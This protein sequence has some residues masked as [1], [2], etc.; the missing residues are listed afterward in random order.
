MDPQQQQQQQ[1]PVLNV[2][3]PLPD[4]VPAPVEKPTIPGKEKLD[5]LVGKAVGGTVIASDIKPQDLPHIDPVR[6]SLDAPTVATTPLLPEKQQPKAEKVNGSAPKTTT[7]TTATAEDKAAATAAASS[8]TV[9]DDIKNRIV[10]AYPQMTRIGWL[11]AYKRTDGPSNEFRDKSIWMDEFASSAMYG[12]FWHNAAAMFLIPVVCFIVFKL[13][14]GFVS[15][16]LIIAF[17]ATYYKNSIRRFRRNARDDLT[18]ELIK[19]AL[20]DNSESVEWINNFM[21]KFWLIYEPVLSATVVGVVD[22]ILVDQTPAFLDSIRLT[23]FTLGTK[24]PRVDNIKTYPHTDPDVVM[25]DWRVSFTPT[26]IEDMTPR[27]LRSQVNPKVVLTVRVGKGIVG[28]GMPILVE[29]MSFKGYFRIKLKLTSNFPHI[30]TL[31]FSF[32]E[33]P[34]IDYVL[35]PVG[36]ETF[37][38]DIAHI[39]GLQSFIRDQTHAILGPMM[40]NPNVFTLDLEQIMTGGASLTA[41]IGV[42]QFTVYN[43]KDLK[44]TELVGNS[45]P[46]MKI[47]L[48]N[49]PELAQTSVKQ[50]TLN[51]IWNETF[52]IL[53]N[54]L[55]EIVVMEI[56]DKDTMRKDRPLGQANFDLKALE[57]DPLQ[58]DVWCKI[59][60]N[61]K[62]R[63]ATRIR[64]AFF[65]IEKP[66]PAED[67]SG[68]LIPV[69][70]NAGIL[71][72]NVAQ[73]KDIARS[74]R[75]K[76]ICNVYLNGKLAH[77]T[78]KLSGTSPAWGAN[79]EMFITDLLN[80]TI[81]FEIVAD[82]EVIGK[83]RSAAVN[84]IDDT[85]NKVDWVTVQGGDGTGKLRLNTEWKPI[86]MSDD[87]NPS[88]HKPAFGVVRIKL[89]AG[90]DLRNVEATGKSDP[91]VVI[92]GDKNVR[93]GRTKI[94]DD[95]L[96]P[97]WNE[98][99]YVA[100]NS[101]KQAIE[102]EVFDYQKLT[103]DRTLGKA[104]F[105]IADL[106]DELPD[107]AGYEARPAIDRW[108]PLLQKDGGAKGELHYVISFHPSLK[109]A[110]EVTAAE[111]AAAPIETAAAAAKEGEAIANLQRAQEALAKATLEPAASAGKDIA[112]AAVDVAAAALPANTVTRED[113]LDYE[114]GILVA[115][116]M[117]AKLDKSN[118][119]CEFYVDSDEYQYK[120]QPQ[121]SRNPKWHE[122]ADIF[123]KELEY[124]KLVVM[125]KEKSSLEKDPIVGVMTG[126]IRTL[127]ETTPP[128]GAEIPILDKTDLRGKIHLKFEYLPVPIELEP[129]ER[130][131]NMGNLSCNLIRGRN[132]LAADRG[133]S[134]DPYVVFRLNGKEVYKSEC[135]K[136]T[137]DPEFGEQFVIPIGSRAEDELVLEVFDWNQ[138]SAAKSLGMARVPLTNLQLVIPNEF[139]LKLQNKSNQ[140]EIHL[141]VKFM[142]EFLS[143]NKRRSGLGSTF[144]SG[145]AHLVT[146]GANLVGN[147][148]MAGINTVGAVGHGAMDVGG[149]VGRGAIKGVGGA[150]KG[151]GA[152]GK[153]VF[154]GLS[155]GASA[156]GLRKDKEKNGSQSTIENTSSPALNASPKLQDTPPSSAVPQ[157]ETPTQSTLGASPSQGSLLSA[158]ASPLPRTSVGSIRSRSSMVFDS[159]DIVGEPGTLT[160][161]II[162]A[163]GLQ[164]VDKSGLSDP[165]VR[166]KMGAKGLFK[167]KVKK[168]NLH[169]VWN[170]DC[171]IPGLTGH[172]VA[173]NFCVKDHNKLGSDKDLGD[174]DLR[175]WEYLQPANES[176]PGEYVADFWAPLSGA[177]GRIHLALAFEP[178]S[179]RRP[180]S[181]RGLFRK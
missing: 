57:L 32:L 115:H 174:F 87:L 33:P 59:L 171:V 36:G 102:L 126:N 163:D 49:R 134:S 130:L 40:Y 105:T 104:G 118:T 99:H 51:P 46:Y 123:V 175:V 132:L 90:R 165:Y 95:N 42:V 152:V 122:V 68:T 61:G 58:D 94:I 62:E 179:G 64:A 60:R 137:L 65:P 78:S 29:D 15:L 25:M 111:R 155:A 110:K 11:E 138:I 27:Q 30:K 178:A 53:V 128:D 5:E 103:K 139:A 154:G 121:K 14:G 98:I 10:G 92:T 71:A 70:S 55:N 151:V 50:D 22:G 114:S 168:E 144:V 167:T 117:G 113:A 52:T 96:N 69:E 79:V 86:L 7:A 101:M 4:D 143:S 12:A 161:Q 120:S 19:N 35:K 176:H 89:L 56:L 54:N 13:G 34:T 148:G 66:K 17:G 173:I 108:A 149:A 9:V 44:N 180:E 159:N 97:V 45:D 37:G 109:V 124:A 93:R 160:V 150:A 76:S 107:K 129:K 31:D 145:G 82:G 181:K 112:D 147:V 85:K 1:Q 88:M 39:P 43:A 2:E 75:T 81:D 77:T 8:A 47:R 21:S 127:L 156:L 177:G 26:D 146:G 116:L 166:V 74:G 83:Y 119:Y 169:P 125:V 73:A 91:Y 136:K 135:V 141:R 38:M 153:G 133:G 84:L 24:A 140:G 170:E 100:V 80:A 20:E 106:V 164:G 6:A 23:T 172:P 18:R 162:E 28:A 142:P 41:S 63:G 157:P 72:V 16:I 3:P 131:D 67:G 48:G 158:S